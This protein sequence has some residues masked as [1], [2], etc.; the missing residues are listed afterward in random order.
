MIEGY[1]VK[2]K[3]DV[4]QGVTTDGLLWYPSSGTPEAGFFQFKTKKEASEFIE[5]VVTVITAPPL[6]KKHFKIEKFDKQGSE[7]LKEIGRLINQSVKIYSQI[8]IGCA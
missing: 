8:G 6:S 4:F 5:K 1:Q 3:E 2:Y 7:K